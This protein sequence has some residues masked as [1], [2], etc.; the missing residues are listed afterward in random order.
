M[1]FGKGQI[2]TRVKAN[3]LVQES[4]KC[5]WKGKWQLIPETRNFCLTSSDSNF[6]A[7]GRQLHQLESLEELQD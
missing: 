6:R 3:K 7:G 4:L 2:D 1:D 5:W